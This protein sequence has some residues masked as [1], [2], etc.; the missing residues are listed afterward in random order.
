MED[1]N[2]FCIRRAVAA[3]AE[4]I[5]HC[6]SRAVHQKGR[7]YYPQD[8]LDLW[9]KPVTPE[10]IQRR[11]EMIEDPE[12]EVYV[13]EAKSDI[14]GFATITPSLNKFGALYV[15][16]NVYGKVGE[17]LAK[18]VIGRGREL[19]LPYFELEGSLSAFEFYKRLGFVE[20]SRGRKETGLDYI[21]MRL[22][23]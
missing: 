15:K 16:P 19:G 7:N 22:E 11:L 4:Q 2:P 8:V 20:T 10:R 1:A 5:T 12:R 23:L 3:D 17:A 21:N 6:H 14:L 9:A 18:T 13:A